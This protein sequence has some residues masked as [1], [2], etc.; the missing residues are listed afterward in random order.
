M[1]RL[2]ALVF[3]SVA[4]LACVERAQGQPSSTVGLTERPLTMVVP[5]AAGGGSDVLARLLAEKLN[6]LI[7]QA[8]IVDN[9]PGANG[10]IASQFVENSKPDGY[11]LMLG[12]NSTHVIAPLLLPDKVTGEQFRKKF[13]LISIVAETPLV[14]AVDGKSAFKDLQEFIVPGSKELTFGTFGVHSSPHL[15]GALLAAQSGARLV[16]IPYKGSAPAITDLLGGQINSVFLTVAAISSYVESGHVRALAVTGRERVATLPDV[17][18][19]GERGIAGLEN[20]GW[21]AIFAPANLPDQIVSYLRAKV[22]EAMSH[23]D[24]QA[25]LRELGLQD[26]KLTTASEVQV[27]DESIARTKDILT[28]T[29]LDLN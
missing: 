9:K 23:S 13:T 2:L 12:S 27:W 16:H 6:A 26:A 17:P 4:L 3:I 1:K 15:M 5:F 21:F 22:R 18:T 10:L 24:M 7:K 28:R 29:G 25:K 11:T 19:F 8:V 20:P 14:L